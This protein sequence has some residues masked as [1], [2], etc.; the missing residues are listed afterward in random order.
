MRAQEAYNLTNKAA[1]TYGPIIL[2]GGK[3]QL[4]AVATW[5]AGSLTLEALGLDGFTYIGV[6]LDTPAGNVANLEANGVGYVD[7]PPGTFQLV[8]TDGAGLSASLARVPMK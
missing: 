7:L 5:D 1:G 6:E 4:V 2:M 3:Y 8:F